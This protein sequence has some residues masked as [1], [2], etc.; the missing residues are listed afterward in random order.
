MTWRWLGIGLFAAALLAVVVVAI[1]GAARAH[2]HYDSACCSGV[3]CRPLDKAEFKMVDRQ[4][5]LRNVQRGKDCGW[6]PLPGGKKW[7]GKG[8]VR[9]SPDFSVHG[10]FNASGTSCLPLCI[11]VGGGV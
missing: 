4:W 2:D 10:C 1:A 5:Y 11:Y 8:P 3:D 7:D 6:K 9:I